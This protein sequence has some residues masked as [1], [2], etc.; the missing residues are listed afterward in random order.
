M[1]RW[2]RN[3]CAV[4]AELP[5][6]FSVICKMCRRTGK[7][8]VYSVRI[9]GNKMADLRKIYPRTGDLQT[10]YLKN[11]VTNPNIEIGDYT[12]YHDFVHDPAEF[13]RN[14]VLYHYPI[15]LIYLS[16]SIVF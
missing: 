2:E 12:M 16:V 8:V 10:V 15:N 4:H 6:R 9:G 3:G 13:E 11:V 1:R 5:F 14:N 7:I